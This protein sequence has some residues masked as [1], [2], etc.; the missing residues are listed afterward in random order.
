[1]KRILIGISI[2]AVVGFFSYS[3]QAN[4]QLKIGYVNSAKIL[5]E[6]PEA[7]EAQKKIDAYQQ[8]IQ[9]SLDIFNKTYQDKLKD[10]QQKESMMTDQSKK[11]AQQ[12][13]VL[14]EQQFN[15]YRDRK[16]SRDGELAQYSA[17]LLDPIKE[18]VLGIIGKVAKK[19]KLSFVFDKTDAIQIL[20]Y[21]ESKY[22]YTNL[23][24][25]QLK[26]G[27]SD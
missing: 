17:K 18:K 24:I 16:L 27:S 8:K 10:Y 25:D 9:D 23:V 15:D 12:D 22:D 11:A 20:L 6:Y 4:S 1:V 21:G 5:Q 2:V 13:L 14:L 19:Q 3:Q 7:Q 26:R